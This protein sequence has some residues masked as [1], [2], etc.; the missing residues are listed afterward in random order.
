MADPDNK[1]ESDPGHLAGL[2]SLATRVSAITDRHS[3]VAVCRSR[4][5]PTPTES[6]LRDPANDS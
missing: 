1:S 3:A 2:L 5:S 4:L 6:P